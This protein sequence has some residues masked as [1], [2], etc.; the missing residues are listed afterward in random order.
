MREARDVCEGTSALTAEDR[1]RIISRIHSLLFWVGEMIPQEITIE[2][3][4]VRLR[5][6]VY[7][8]ITNDAPTEQ[9]QEDAAVLAEL[10]DRHVREIEADIKHGDVSRQQACDLMNE[11]RS[12][13]RAVDELRNARGEAAE[14]KRQDL[15][16]RI[17]DVRRWQRFVDQVR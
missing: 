16:K 11:A 13:L 15:M 14:I 9:E 10:L 2:D 7:H 12:I 17:E 8:Y 3:R 4:S 6:T 5:D 1:G